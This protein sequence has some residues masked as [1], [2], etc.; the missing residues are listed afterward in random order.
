MAR[1]RTKTRI[2]RQDLEDVQRRSKSSRPVREKP[3]VPTRHADPLVPIPEREKRSPSVK[4]HAAL[5]GGDRFSHPANAGRKA[6]A[7]ARLQ[8]LYGNKYVQRA[9]RQMTN[10]GV[11]ERI[12][13]S[14]DAAREELQ[15]A[16]AVRGEIAVHKG[17]GRPLDAK[18]L[19]DA[20]ASFGEDFKDVR[21]H[22]DAEANSL[23]AEFQA[24]ALTVGKDVFFAEGAYQPQTDAGAKLL[25][26]ELTH[27]AEGGTRDKIAFWGGADHEKLTRKGAQNVMPR[28]GKLINDLAFYCRQ[29]DLRVRRIAKAAVPHIWGKIRGKR[30]LAEGPEHGEDGNYTTTD[31]GSAA[32]Q[33]IKEQRKHL[34]R[35]L[36]H[37][38][39]FNRVLKSKT[40]TMREKLGKLASINKDIAERLGDALHIAQDRG[41]HW[42][43]VAGRGHDDPNDLAQGGKK[44]TDDPKDNPVGF[45]VAYTHTLEVLKEYWA[46]RNEK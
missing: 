1:K 33:N 42:E 3:T 7:V 23:A 30:L 46:R 14:E 6:G 10:A 43:G 4:P 16:G 20:E 29:M 38:K 35:A 13:R 2:G 12:K 19:L 17:S 24:N 21:V 18:T 45:G 31:L 5:L 34:E 25:G 9:L 41:S 27:V 36:Q 40:E 15:E 11:P 28:Q 8:Q 32:S 44:N 26:H 39:R 37:R 22:S